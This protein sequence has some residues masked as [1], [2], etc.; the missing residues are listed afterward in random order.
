M[1]QDTLEEALDPRSAL[2]R[3]VHP[4]I[5]DGSIAEVLYQVKSGK[6]AVVYCCRAGPR[7]SE[8]HPLL[9]AK[10]YKPR[11]FRAFRNEAMYRQGRV[12]LDQRAARAYASRSD[13]GERVATA[14]WTGAEW[15]TLCRLQ[16]AGADVPRPLATSSNALL[17]EFLGDEDGA[18]PLL[19]G[20][21]LEQAEAEAVFDRLLDN[22]QLW[23]AYDV[24]HADLSAYNVL[25][26][27]D[28]PWVIDFPQSC[29]PRFN[30][31]AFDLL[32]R[33]IRNLANY[34]ER[35]GVVR[36][37]FGLADSY[38]RTWERGG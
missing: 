18:A 36:D 23:L 24:V 10:V 2:L 15:E 11:A 13:F 29:D 32:L 26:W 37:A 16:A 19:K 4:F 27:Q 6:E 34:F 5:A 9:A 31:N 3:G 35:S 22:V 25:Y 28:Q 30:T 17:L 38:W 14:T 1:H 12:I 7:F 8:S 21:R 20:L 33:D